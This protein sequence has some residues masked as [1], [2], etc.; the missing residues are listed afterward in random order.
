LETRSKSFTWVLEDEDASTTPKHHT[1]ASEAAPSVPPSANFDNKEETN[2]EKEGENAK[3]NDSL[4]HKNKESSSSTE[5]KNKTDTQTA[6][7][8]STFI[9]SP[10]PPQFR[11]QELGVGPVKLL[12]TVG[13]PEKIR[14]V[15][16]RE[17]TPNGP[18]T[19]VIL[20]VPIWKE[21]RSNQSSEKHVRLTTFETGDSMITHLFKFKTTDEASMFHHQLQAVIGTSKSCVA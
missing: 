15:Q 1:T 6:A 2:Q 21:S 9:N 18:A 20:N 17:S 7:S 8:T 19:K 4:D 3:D 14:L 16:R 5:T 12:Q 13:N 10:E 11:W